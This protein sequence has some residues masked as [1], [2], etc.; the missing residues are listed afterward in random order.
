MEKV[1]R[2]KKLIKEV[3]KSERDF[4]M[5]LGIN[6]AT[7]NLY[8]LEKRKLSLDVIEAILEVYPNISAEWLLRGEGNMFCREASASSS[9]DNFYKRVID[10]QLDTISM[11]KKKVAELESVLSSEGKSYVV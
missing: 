8:M 6:P 2:I 10:E 9:D 4:S 7:L 3:S 1:E 5:K 11:L